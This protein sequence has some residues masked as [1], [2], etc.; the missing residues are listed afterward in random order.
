MDE[1][2]EPIELDGWPAKIFALS[3]VDPDALEVGIKYYEGDSRVG[4][5]VWLPAT[6]SRIRYRF[7]RN[8]YTETRDEFRANLSL[9]GCRALLWNREGVLSDVTIARAA[10]FTGDDHA[11]GNWNKCTV[12]LS[13][14]QLIIFAPPSDEDR[15]RVG[16]PRA[17]ESNA[18]RQRAYRKRQKALRNSAT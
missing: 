3:G 10:L 13:H 18:D 15:Q 7:T 9:N 11:P 14:P 16:R 4:K 6:S 17:F 5:A 8:Y 12:P 2:G 1:W